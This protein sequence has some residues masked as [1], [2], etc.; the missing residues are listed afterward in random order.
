MVV[1]F[2]LSFT[3][4]S[5][6]FPL[7]MSLLA[8]GC[9]WVYPAACSKPRRKERPFCSY[10]VLVDSNKEQLKSQKQKFLLQLLGMRRGRETDF[11]RTCRASRSMPP[12]NCA[13]SQQTLGFLHLVEYFPINLTERTYTN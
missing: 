6:C 4:L 13:L 9:A 1:P 3:K 5:F 2:F 11:M 8:W 12:S 7:L 10:C